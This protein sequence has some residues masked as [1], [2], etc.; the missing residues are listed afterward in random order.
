MLSTATSRILLNGDPGNPLHHRRGLRQGDPLAPMLFI[1]ALEPLQQIFQRATDSG[2]LSALSHRAARMRTSFYADDAAIF[3]N[4]IKEE[5]AA[6]FQLLDFFG[7][8]SGLRI[9]VNKCTAY[10]IRCKAVDQND[11]L[12]VFGGNIG[13]LPCTYLGWG[14]LSISET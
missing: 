10:P 8:T 9:N 5:V 3:L 1:L 12:G 4:P 14:F 7:Q 6:V 11:L 2:I 13:S